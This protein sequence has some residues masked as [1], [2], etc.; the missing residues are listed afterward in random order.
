M[1]GA[2]GATARAPIARDGS[3]SLRGVQE[4]PSN[5]QMPPWAP[6]RTNVPSSS[7]RRAPMRPF[8][9]TSAPL[10]R[11]AS[12]IGAGPMF[13]QV[14]PKEAGLVVAGA[15]RAALRAWAA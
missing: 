15:L 9:G 11:V 4:V 5:V 3:P 2:D 6:P 7:M 8:M 13:D 1:L 12:L 14:P 10:P